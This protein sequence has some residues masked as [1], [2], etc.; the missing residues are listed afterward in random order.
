MA[1]RNAEHRRWLAIVLVDTRIGKEMISPSPRRE[2][3][4]DARRHNRSRPRQR[5]GT[6][7]F[8][9]SRVLA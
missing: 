6:L 2:S 4:D 9:A 3:D 7:V 1:S 5:A 8:A